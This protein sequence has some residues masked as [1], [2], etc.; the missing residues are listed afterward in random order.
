MTVRTNPFD[1]TVTAAHTIAAFEYLQKYVT[2][3]LA[4]ASS[5][6]AG[7]VQEHP[8]A[9]NDNRYHHRNL[10]LRRAAMPNNG[11]LHGT[12]SLAEY[13]AMNSGLYSGPDNMNAAGDDNQSGN[14]SPDDSRTD[15]RNSQPQSPDA[16]R[17]GQG[18]GSPH[19]S[20]LEKIASKKRKR[21]P[22]FSSSTLASFANESE[23]EQVPAS[24][25]DLFEKGQIAYACNMNL[26]VSPLTF[27]LPVIMAEEARENG[28]DDDSD[29]DDLAY[30]SYFNFLIRDIGVTS[31]I[32]SSAHGSAWSRLHCWQ[33]SWKQRTIDAFGKHA[34]TLRETNVTLDNMSHADRILLLNS[35]WKPDL[36]GDLIPFV[37]KYIDFTASCTPDQTG[38]SPEQVAARQRNLKWFKN[39]YVWIAYGMIKVTASSERAREGFDRAR[40]CEFVSTLCQ[41]VRPADP[42]DLVMKPIRHSV[43]QRQ[44]KMPK[45]PADLF[46]GFSIVT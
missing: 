6:C 13:N 15:L 39:L 30:D 5:V 14:R 21:A 20:P 37:D 28:E 3:S 34:Q 31:G 27:K 32:N 8:L 10:P 1:F 24:L 12:M 9:E 18:N 2:S 22:R 41:G 46:P 36:M 26:S 19:A 38:L 35:T 29:E 40:V 16:Q 25:K 11:P 33:R 44:L 23:S 4:T 45:R 7:L 42:K 17:T 43:T